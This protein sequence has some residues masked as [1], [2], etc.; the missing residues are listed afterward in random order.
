MTMISRKTITRAFFVARADDVA[1]VIDL[2]VL[3]VVVVVDSVA[4]VAVAA[5]A[6]IFLLLCRLLLL[7]HLEPHCVVVVVGGRV[8]DLREFLT[9]G[10]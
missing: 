10:Y 9:A 2:D 1:D 4:F 6:S 5:A 3:V 7:T 8:D